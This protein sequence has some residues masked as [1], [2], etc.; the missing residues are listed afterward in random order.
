MAQVILSVSIQEKVPVRQYLTVE[1]ELA[2]IAQVQERTQLLKSKTDPLTPEEQRTRIQGERAFERL[3]AD[4]KGTICRLIH[5]YNFLNR[6]AFDEM[7]QIALV[8]FEKAVSSFNPKCSGKQRKFT[9]W[10]FLKISSKYISLYRSEL[11]FSRKVKSAYD[12]LRACDKPNEYRPPNP[13]PEASLKEIILQEIE[14][15]L[16]KSDVQ[17]LKDYYFHE[18]PAKEIALSFG[19]SSAVLYKRK[20]NSLEQLRTNP[21][22]QELAEAYI[23]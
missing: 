20:R 5:R 9:S 18:Y 23:A 13:L 8:A 7:Y 14:S 1:Q 10:V 3:L 16:P 6:I 19:Y 11:V 2:L 22:L 17:I 12:A 15:S 4:N 21:R